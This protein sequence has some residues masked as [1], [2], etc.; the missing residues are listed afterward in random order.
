MGIGE[1]GNLPGISG[2]DELMIRGL[3]IMAD[4]VH[5]TIAGKIGRL[6]SEEHTPV[7]C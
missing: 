5:F 7:L 4:A 2:A 6:H 3:A 1:K